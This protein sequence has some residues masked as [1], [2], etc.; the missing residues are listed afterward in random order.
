MIDFTV[1]SYEDDLLI[2]EIPYVPSVEAYGIYRSLRHD[3]PGAFQSME[4]SSISPTPERPTRI[5]ITSRELQVTG[6]ERFLVRLTGVINGIE[7]PL[8]MSPSVPISPPGAFKLLRTMT[9]RPFTCFSSNMLA[10]DMDGV[11]PPSGVSVI[12]DNPIQVKI[13]TLNSTVSHASDGGSV[14][15]YRPDVERIF[16]K[17]SVEEHAS[18]VVLGF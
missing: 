13:N 11:L 4:M 7:T 8:T 2:L 15:L 17:T 3:T 12:S 18:V 9:V 1:V 14:D 5:S 10:V 6:N 16:L